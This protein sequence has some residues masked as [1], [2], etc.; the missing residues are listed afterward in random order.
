MSIATEIA[1]Y[2]RYVSM[3]GWVSQRNKL[4]VKSVRHIIAYLR[5]ILQLLR[6]MRVIRVS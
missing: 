3:Y 2:H 6:C 5:D 4:I 1:N